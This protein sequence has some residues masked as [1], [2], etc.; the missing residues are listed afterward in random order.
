MPE[1]QPVANE[2][3]LATFEKCSQ[4]SPTSLDF[5]NQCSRPLRAAPAGWRCYADAPGR[6]GWIARAAER[7]GTIS[8]PLLLHGGNAILTVGF[9][10]SYEG[11]GPGEIWL[12]D[13]VGR[14]VRLNGTWDSPTSEPD[15]LVI[16]AVTLCGKTCAAASA[17]P[18]KKG[19]HRHTAHVRMLP[20]PQGSTRKFKLLLLESC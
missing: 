13:D 6:Q 14:A 16:P 20:E 4:N 11:F 5:S 9:L 12:D 2:A 7:P 3:E 1:P 8:F 15:L 10:R 18:G 19:N 17:T